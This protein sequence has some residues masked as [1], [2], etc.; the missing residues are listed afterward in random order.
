VPFLTIN[1]LNRV[2]WI[3]FDCAD[4]FNVL[5]CSLRHIFYRVI[6]FMLFRF[7]PIIYTC[8]SARRMVLFIDIS[9]QG[10][11]PWML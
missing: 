8:E 1:A 3:I 10:R 7:D 11:K 5:F 4:G 9:G 6:N 2:A